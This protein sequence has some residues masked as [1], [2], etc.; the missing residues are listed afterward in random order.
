MCN[1]ISLAI[2]KVTLAKKNMI[3]WGEM[4]QRGFGT[5]DGHMD[6]LQTLTIVFTRIGISPDN[7]QTFYFFVSLL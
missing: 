4:K 5:N 1:G 2:C 6:F 7:F 3:F